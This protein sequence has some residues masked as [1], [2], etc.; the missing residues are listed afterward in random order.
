MKK[1][2]NFWFPDLKQEKKSIESNS[3]FDIL[4][5]ENP[6]KNV[7]DEY[8]DICKGTVVRSRKI[9]IYPNDEQKKT[10]Q[11]W[12][13]DY[14]DIYNKTNEFIKSKIFKDD[15]IVDENLKF[16]N[17]R[18]IR[19][20]QMKEY[21][22]E[23]VK[24]TKINKHLLDEAIKNNVAMYKSCISNKKNKNIK[25]F[26]VRPLSK[27]KRR[28]N[29]HIETNLISKIEKN[30]SFCSSI[31]GDMK[32]EDDFKLKNIKHTFILQY[33]KYYNKYYILV[34]FDIKKVDNI[35]DIKNKVP[36][37][38]KE[39]R[40]Y[41]KLSKNNKGNRIKTKS[42]CAIDPG[43]RTAYTLYSKN[44]TLEI[45]NK[46]KS[47]LKPFFNK[48]DNTNSTKDTNKISEKKYNKCITRIY[49]KMHNKIKDMHWKT[50][51][52]LCKHFSTICIG[53]IS[54]SNIVNN[55]KSNI[56]EIT[57]RELYALSHYKFRQILE[58]QCEKFN[59]EYKEINEYETSKRCHK[60][61]KINNVGSSKIYTCDVCKISLD[62]DVNASINIYKK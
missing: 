35:S 53:K 28:K 38:N 13:N 51:N 58:H 16:V 20:K 10:L 39:R 48:I 62:R 30:N 41:L 23:L 15:E 27:E 22:E 52:Y 47:T 14:I 34:P 46:I 26:R 54:T 49:T 56:K 3:W 59:C 55:E 25:T 45:G 8:I 19:D 24:N 50:S 12:F 17:F 11:K 31:L 37:T 6:V 29:L 44:E 1:S 4:K 33:D 60:C 42:K 9:F 36:T 21:K 40:R 61:N 43:I 7:N 57:K 2:E 5:C 18:D 32:T